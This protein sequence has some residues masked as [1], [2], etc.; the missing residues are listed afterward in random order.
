MPNRVCPLDRPICPFS[1]PP[2]MLPLAALAIL[3]AGGVKPAQASYLVITDAQTNVSNFITALA[4]YNLV[5]T[6]STFSTSNGG[7]TGIATSSGTVDTT[8]LLTASTDQAFVSYTTTGTQTGTVYSA[9]NL[10]SG[11][12]K[13]SNVNVS[14]SG[15]ASDTTAQFN[16]V[17]HYT[18]AGATSSSTT[19]VTVEFALDGTFSASN[20]ALGQVQWNMGFG[21]A[22][23]DTLMEAD[24]TNCAGTYPTPCIYTQTRP[25][26][27][28]SSFTSDTAGNI[29][30]TGVYAIHGATAD[31]PVSGYLFIASGGG[32]SSS[33]DYSHTAQ[34]ILPQAAGVSYTSDSR[35]F[36][37]GSATAPE[38]ASMVLIGFGMLALGLARRRLYR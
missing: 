15:V 37:T 35:V 26:W 5:A 20:G 14:L 3:L 33:F 11:T 19:D 9:A 36:L 29:I 16:D 22:S 7:N 25:G 1:M 2:G 30:F 31:I 27:V 28:S 10:A 8:G 13:A 21:T 12:L 17:L 38:P 32:A 24:P 6:G 18:I 4:D 23:L 34:F